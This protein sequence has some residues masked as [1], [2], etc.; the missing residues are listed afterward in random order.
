MSERTVVVA[1]DTE[2]L[3][4]KAGDAFR[5][6][7][8]EKEA[9]R[10]VGEFETPVVPE[11]GHQFIYHGHTY[12]RPLPWLENVIRKALPVCNY[13]G[14]DIAY[15]SYQTFGSSIDGVKLLPE[16]KSS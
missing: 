2:N 13:I 5:I 14:I 7:I 9:R 12:I 16:V 10:A 4:W 6:N 15:G 11:Y 8:T 1:G 3:F